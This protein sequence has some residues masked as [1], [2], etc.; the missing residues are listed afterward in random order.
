MARHRRN[1]EPELRTR[2]KAGFPVPNQGGLTPKRSPPRSSASNR[3][4]G[5][6]G[7][8]PVGFPRS[9]TRAPTAPGGQVPSRNKPPNRKA[10][11]K[12]I[13][14]GDNPEFRALSR[15]E[16][17]K[18]ER[19]FGGGPGSGRSNE[20][21][22]RAAVGSQAGDGAGPA[23]G[24]KNIADA[25]SSLVGP[26]RPEQANDAVLNAQAGGSAD[27]LARAAQVARDETEPPSQVGPPDVAAAVQG[28]VQETS[29]PAG[30]EGEEAGPQIDVNGNVVDPRG[31]P[32][33]QPGGVPSQQVPGVMQKAEFNVERPM[34]VQELQDGPEGIYNT[35]NGQ[36]ERSVDGQ[37]SVRG[38]SERG[39]QRLTQLKRGM[40][41][42]FGRWSGK[43]DPDA[44]KPPI[45][46][47]MPAFNPDTGQWIGL[48][49]TL[50]IQ[51]D[52]T[53][54]IG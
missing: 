50:S 40:E 20:E 32:S 26:P 37:I 47:G 23:G 30:K 25:Q 12:R 35:P 48:E 41:R 21:I 31:G 18:I 9:L 38:M 53:F 27:M 46:P 52:G 1:K 22:A 13:I 42:D 29:G 28:L 54:E 16:Q 34:S 10:A 7:G 36:I 11:D 19:A 17:I 14:P 24:A 3:G 5:S 2:A 8:R 45:V 15:P 6:R 4:G 44:P 33:V 49:N 43:N 51:P 39:K